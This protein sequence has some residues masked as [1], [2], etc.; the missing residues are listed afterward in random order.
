[1]IP[2]LVSGVALLL[3]GLVVACSGPS[4]EARQRKRQR[5]RLQRQERLRNYLLSKGSLA[6]DQ[7][8]EY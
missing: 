4:P 1:M 8:G 2:L 3:L 6:E 5:Q 7:E